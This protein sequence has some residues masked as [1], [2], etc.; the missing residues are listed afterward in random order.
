MNFLRTDY[1]GV[2]FLLLFLFYGLFNLEALVSATKLSKCYTL[3]FA[4]ITFVLYQRLW[5]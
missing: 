3:H 1:V 2:F 5:R 4:V